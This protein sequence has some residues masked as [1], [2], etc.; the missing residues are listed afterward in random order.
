MIPY[1]RFLDCHLRYLDKYKLAERNFK[2]RKDDILR[3]LDSLISHPE[4][5]KAFKTH[6]LEVK[7]NL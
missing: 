4:T 2:A 6:L 7:R 5:G 3:S 1:K